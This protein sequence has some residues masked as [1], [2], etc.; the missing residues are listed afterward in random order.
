M[1]IKIS[2]AE[3]TFF[4]QLAI[5]VFIIGTVVAIM[6][7]YQSSSIY[8]SPSYPD[9]GEYTEEELR[10]QNVCLSGPAPTRTGGRGVCRVGDTCNSGG[11]CGA[12]CDD[13]NYPYESR[14]GLCIITGVLKSNVYCVRCEA[15]APPKPG[16]PLPPTTT[17]NTQANNYPGG[18]PQISGEQSYCMKPESDGSAPMDYSLGVRYTKVQ[19]TTCQTADGK[20]GNCYY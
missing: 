1:A 3:R 8:L 13:V 16:A 10:N 20:K 5:G 2:G 11:T 9:Y 17:V 7:T 15:A 19:G 14:T 6:N 18:C 4:W 12:T